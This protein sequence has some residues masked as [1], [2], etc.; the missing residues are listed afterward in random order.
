LGPWETV[1]RIPIVREPRLTERWFFPAALVSLA[2]LAATA[3]LTSRNRALSRRRQELQGEV[4]RHTEALRQRTTDL[5]ANQVELLTRSR[6]IEEQAERLRGLDRLKSE[7]IADIAHELR[8]PLT[9]LLGS[10]EQGEPADVGVARRNAETL[11]LLVE[12]LFQLQDLDKGKLPLRARRID[13]ARSVADS[14]GQFAEAFAAAGRELVGPEPGAFIEL[15][16]NASAVR[17]ITANLL[18]N[19]LRYG[20][21]RTEVRLGVEGVV[22]RIEVLDRGPGV[23]PEDRARVFERFVQ[24]STGDTRVAE[25]MGIGLAMVREL[26]ELHGGEVGVDDAPGGGA[27]FWLTLPLGSDHL[28]VDDIESEVTPLRVFLP[29]LAPEPPEPPAA[30]PLLLVVED[31]DELRS[32]LVQRLVSR[33]RVVEA[34]DGGEGLEMALAHRPAAI[35]SDVRMPRKDGLQMARELRAHPAIGGTP[36][37]FLSA[38]AMVEDRVEGLQVADDYLCKPFGTQELLLR[39]ARLVDG[40][41]PVEP[42]PPVHVQELLDRLAATADRRMAEPEFGVAQLAKAMAMSTRTLQDRMKVLDLP[43]P[44]PWLLERRLTRAHALLREGRLETV[45]EVAGA[46]GMSPAYLSRAYRAWSGLSP[47]EELR[48]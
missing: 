2:G 1:A 5:E 19:A 45:G 42:G 31:N 20:Q 24:L 27:R 34:R 47:S 13:L 37:M 10:L 7:F 17:R 44:G 4:D 16:A 28:T 33:Y 23:P 46:V 39:L 15:W 48:R 6:T 36:V 14:V 12:Q 41:S 40:A 38:K 26:I 29:P 30:G 18:Q 32:W 11:H 35:L 43:P 3:A 9:L 8:T 22:A 25:G 21:G